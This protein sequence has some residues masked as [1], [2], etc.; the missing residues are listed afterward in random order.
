MITFPRSLPAGA[1]VRV[2]APVR[3]APAPLW[4]STQ[5]AGTLTLVHGRVT[6]W[7]A[8]AVEALPVAANGAG[9]GFAAAPPA[10]VF[11]QGENGGLVVADA[12]ADMGCFSI[13]L[14]FAPGAQEPRTL[15][16]VQ[17]QGD[18][19]Y[20]F[21][22]ADGGAVRL[23][24]KGGDG[25]LSL[26]MPPAGPLLVICSRRGADLWLSVNADA[27]VAGQTNAPAQSAPGDLFVGCRDGRGGR[28]GK[29]GSFRLTDVFIWPEAIL[30]RQALPASLLAVLSE[31]QRHGV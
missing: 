23:G 21:L 29:L 27:P 17:A 5:D 20:L 28:T 4:F 7:Q 31:R 10:L 22:S 1:L 12:L 18:D 16:S 6:R 3:E 9:T 24:Q 13:G 19:G 30:A 14:I 8:G 15:L 11:A 2:D 26:P 25:A